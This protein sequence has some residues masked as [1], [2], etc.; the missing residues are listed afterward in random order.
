MFV[1]GALGCV[2]VIILTVIEDVRTLFG[3]EDD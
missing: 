2:A 3:R 1:V